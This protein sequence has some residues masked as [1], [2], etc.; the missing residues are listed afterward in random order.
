VALVA[1]AADITGDIIFSNAL[2]AESLYTVRSGENTFVLTPDRGMIRSRNSPKLLSI[3]NRSRTGLANVTVGP[4][5]AAV[6]SA[7]K[8]PGPSLKLRILERVLHE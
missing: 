5:S 2:L 8:R 7:H 4:Q 1:L 3:D 6:Q